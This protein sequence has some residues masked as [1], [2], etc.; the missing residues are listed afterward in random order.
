MGG[1]GRAP[2]VILARMFSALW[3]F[4]TSPIRLQLAM[5]PTMWLLPWMTL[6][7]LLMKAMLTRSLC[8]VLL[9]MWCGLSVPVVV[10]LLTAD[11][12]VVGGLKVRCRRLVVSVVLILVSG[13]L[14]CMMTASVV[15]LHNATLASLVADSCALFFLFGSSCALF[16]MMV[17]GLSV[18]CMIL[19]SV[20][21]D[22]GIRVW[23]L[24]GGTVV[25]PVVVG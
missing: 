19:V 2:N 18:L 17:S 9:P 5:P 16:F 6:L 22:V 23:V 4:V 24:P 21:L 12:G 14:V 1:I 10:M 7:C 15:G 25:V 20:P 8:V 13:A 11:F 3:S